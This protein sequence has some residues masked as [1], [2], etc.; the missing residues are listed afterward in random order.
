[1]LFN[2]AVFL[3][4][5]LPVTYFVFW[6]LRTKTARYIWLAIS[7]YVFYGYWNP[8]FCL[9]MLFSTLVS[10]SAGLGFLRWPDDRRMRKWLL[11]TPITVDLLLLGVFK[12][13]SLGIE[14][15]NWV[16]HFWPVRPPIDP[17]RIILPIGISFYTFHTITYIVDSY[18]RQ[19]VPTHNFSS[20]FACYVSLLFSQL[21][22]GPIVA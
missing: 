13:T 21:V 4:L 11:V 17:I 12:Y 3:F 7:G 14:T 20:E 19:I 8:K 16:L 9:L 6:T 10:Y 22:A 5:F 15:L 1:M 18:R 2:S